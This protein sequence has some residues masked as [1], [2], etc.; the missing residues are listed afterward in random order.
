MALVVA[1]KLMV[2]DPPYCADVDQI[3]AAACEA[4]K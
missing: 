1:D 3:G 4:A 2:L